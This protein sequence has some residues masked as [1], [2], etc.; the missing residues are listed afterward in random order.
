MQ[1]VQRVWRVLESGGM[2]GAIWLEWLPPKALYQVTRSPS[3]N[4][5]VVTT[6]PSVI[7]VEPAY[8][9][10]VESFQPFN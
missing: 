2:S 5:L 10:P 4:S 7:R 9:E 6:G 3:G 1:L 8:N